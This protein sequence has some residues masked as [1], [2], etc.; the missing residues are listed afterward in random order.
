MKRLWTI[1][2][3][4]LVSVV[5]V[6]QTVSGLRQLSAVAAI[7]ANEGNIAP[8]LLFT[9]KG[10]YSGI[11]AISMIPLLAIRKIGED[12]KLFIPFIVLLFTSLAYYLTYVFI[13]L[14]G[15]PTLDASTLIFMFIVIV[16]IVLFFI[17]MF[18][19]NILVRKILFMIGAISCSAIYIVD[20]V[21]MAIPFGQAIT[22]MFSVTTEEP[23]SVVVALLMFI[24]LG[25]TFLSILIDAIAL[26]AFAVGSIS[27]LSTNGVSG[28][29][30]QKI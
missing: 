18:T 11:G 17:S 24:V 9:L 20:I 13:S 26:G 22:A 5:L 27:V 14:G 30:E 21:I 4:A 6:I 29:S 10:V 25:E 23:L 19:R 12:K 1:L 2:S 28:G 15:M 3:A 7:I 8:F 16:G